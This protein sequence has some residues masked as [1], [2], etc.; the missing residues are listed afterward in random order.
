MKSVLL[1]A[2]GTFFVFISLSVF[3]TTHFVSLNSTN[4]VAPFTDWSTAATNIQDAIDAASPNDLILVTNGIYDA[5]G[6]LISGVPTTNRVAVTQALTLQSI[7][8]PAV[9]VIRGYQVP[10][11]TNG[12][13]AVR[14]VYLTNGAGLIGFTVT[15]G[16]TSA[17]TGE[18]GGIW[19]QTAVDNT[20]SVLSNCVVAGNAAGY[21]GGGVYGGGTLINCTISNNWAHLYGGGAYGAVLVG[22]WL[23]GNFPGASIQGFLTNCVLA[24]NIGLA[25]YA[26]KLVNCTIVG[27]S[28]GG[29][30]NSLLVANCIVYYNGPPGSNYSDSAIQSSCTIPAVGNNITNDPTFVDL[31]NGDYHLQSISPCINSGK[32]SFIKSNA[33]FD[34]N[35]RI[36]GGTVDI[37]AYEFQTPSSFISY[38]WLQRYGLPTDGSAD[39]V[40]TDGDGMNNW[41]EWI[42]GTDP[43][44]PSSILKMLTPTNGASGVTASWESVNTRTYFLQR[45][46]NLATEPAF[47]PIRSNIVG[48]TGTTTYSDSTATNGGPYFYRVGVQ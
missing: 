9:T 10:G 20:S 43:T 12:A 29:V 46:G 42:A 33:D 8:G 31:N 41:Q 5:G 35:A 26:D 23:Q 48:Q 40:D 37:G 25:S 19:F 6:R 4:P 28:G 16:A 21:G 27:N 24:G 13:A 7:N 1:R 38:A 34:G 18:G 39:F 22:C 17:T 14:C 36:V 2:A 30:G 15:N 11:T 3:A 47:S 44:N 32:N 45:A